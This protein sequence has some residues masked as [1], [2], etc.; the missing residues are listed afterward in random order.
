VLFGIADKVTGMCLKK[1]P[2]LWP[3]K[4]IL[5]HDNAPAHEAVRVHEFLA[6]NFITKVD[7]PPKSPD[8]APGDFCLFPK[9]KIALKGQR[10]AA[11]SDIQ[12]N[13]KT[14]LQGVSEI[15]FQIIFGS[16]TIVT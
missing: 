3:D 1:R 13:V 6:E 12:R 7:H 10:F 5:H 11:L 16:G 14:L 8:I 2:R 15:D 9:L 4:C